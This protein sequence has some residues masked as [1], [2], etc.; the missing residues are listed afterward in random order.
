ASG[1]SVTHSY[2][3]PGTY[4]ILVTATGPNSKSARGELTVVILNAP[5]ENVSFSYTPDPAFIG[6]GI[7]FTA[8]QSRGTNLQYKWVFSDGSAAQYGQTIGKQ[9]RKPGLVEVR[10]TAW[11]DGGTEEYSRV[12]PVNAAPPSSLLVI[13]NGPKNPGE[14]VTFVLFVNSQAP[15]KIFYRWGDRGRR[16]VTLPD[17]GPDNPFYQHTEVYTYREALRYPFMV[18]VANDFGLIREKQIVY[19]GRNAASEIRVGHR[20]PSPIFPG[21][22]IPFEIT[23]DVGSDK[24]GWLFSDPNARAYPKENPV[25]GKNVEYNF[26]HT[27]GHVVTIECKDG[28]VTTKIQEFVLEVM[29]PMF[30]PLVNNV[31]DFNSTP[32]PTPTPTPTTGRQ[33]PVDTPTPVNTPTTTSAAEPTNTATATATLVPATPTE[34]VTATPTPIPATPTVT[35]TNT[36]VPTSPASSPPTATPTTVPGGTIPGG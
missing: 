5:P 33:G 2:G 12:V 19:I 25:L 8:K 22:D 1:S 14:P 7:A 35:P 20:Y 3:W 10:V 27:G 11:N 32:E 4:R 15:I 30:L 26:E 13:Q 16:V 24:C 9:F 31:N 23:E 28:N 34:T 17:Q 36:F 6:S 21:L 18:T 29:D